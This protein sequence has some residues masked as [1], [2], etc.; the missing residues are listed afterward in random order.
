MIS[1]EPLDNNLPYL[2]Q[3]SIEQAL[4]RP[5][6]LKL[7]F[8]GL[9]II[10]VFVGSFV[11]WSVL[12]PLKGAV[13]SPGIVSVATNRK[14]IQ[15]LEGGIIESILVKDGDTVSKGQLLIKLRDTQPAA[16]LR[17]LER[18]YIEAQT[19]LARLLSERDN[20]KN[21]NFPA[22]L[23][24]RA[25]EDAAV[26]A[27]ITGQLNILE[28]RRAHFAD[29]QS[30]I[31]Y[32]ISQTRE[33]IKGLEEQLKTRSEQKELITEELTRIE[34][35]VNNKLITQSEA[36]KLKTQLSDSEVD[37]N[38][39]RTELK[40]LNQTVLE[41]RLQISEIQAKRIAE[42]SEEIRDQRATLYTLSQKIGTVRDT[43]TRTNIRSPIDG[44]VV[45]LQV[46]TIDGIIT[47][48]QDILEVVP[49]GDDL[50][51]D[52]FIDPKDIDEV[53]VGMTADVRLTSLSRRERTPIAG[54]V[55]R[56]SADRI[57][58]KNSGKE[59]YQAK[60]DLTPETIDPDR[61][62]L[63]PGMG[64]DVFIQTG[65]RSAFDYLIAPIADSLQLS[66]REK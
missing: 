8:A 14:Q 37:L 63:I 42:I 46:H 40:R 49:T 3:T 4:G 48:G 66:L 1:G 45:S 56:I 24:K 12:A 25:D 7:I 59:Y 64:A 10:L 53:R 26:Q 15:H 41:L 21:I 62:Q 9:F 30:V 5:F 16:E 60:I 22:D 39:I 27:I 23:Q 50:V 33:Q 44:V 57:F 54:T 61:P 11:A 31:K 19:I 58:D 43:L 18:E 36:Y 20:S 28:S 38:T 47:A 17:R 52:A 65:A 32:K 55:S 13:V 34:D 6:P 2:N 51:I 29:Q 35:A